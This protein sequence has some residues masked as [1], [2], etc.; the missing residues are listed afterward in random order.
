LTRKRLMNF[1]KS[2]LRTPIELY[3]HPDEE[4]KKIINSGFFEKELRIKKK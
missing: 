4:K 3:T 1:R 2:E